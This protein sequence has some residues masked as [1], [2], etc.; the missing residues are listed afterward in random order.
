[1]QR[2]TATQW[3][4]L[5]HMVRPASH[6]HAPDKAQCECGRLWDHEL[7][8]TTARELAALRSEPAVA[9]EKGS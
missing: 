3:Q 8:A 5:P 4:D 1:M 6:L 2:E 9:T 7:H